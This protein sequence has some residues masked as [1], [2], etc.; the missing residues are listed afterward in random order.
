MFAVNPP[1]PAAAD[2]AVEIKLT[3]VG[4]ALRELGIGW[5][6]AHSPQAQG[7]IERFFGTAQDR[8]VKGLRLAGA[9]TL[10]EAKRLLGAG[11]PAAVEPA[12]HRA[13]GELGTY[14]AIAKLFL[15]PAALSKCPE[16][17]RTPRQ[18]FHSA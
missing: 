1:L 10:E 2:E 14:P 16:R 9:H 15:M 7:R 11:I 18:I 3:Q 4:R 17:G 5:I 8:L 6:A 12:F 13:G